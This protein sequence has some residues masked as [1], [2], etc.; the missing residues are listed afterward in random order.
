VGTSVATNKSE[1]KQK[2]SQ[3]DGKSVD[4]YEANKELYHEL[5][6]ALVGYAETDD[7]DPVRYSAETH[8]LHR[9]NVDADDVLYFLAS[10]TL[11][12]K[13]CG[14]VLETV[15][16]KLWNVKAK[17]YI[18]E[19]LQVSDAKLFQ[20]KG[21]FSLVRKIKKLIDQ[22]GR[23]KAS[24]ILNATGGFKATIPYMT[25]MGLIEGI[26]VTYIYE[27]QGVLIELPA[28]PLQFDRK[29]LEQLHQKS[30]DLFE[31]L[32]QG[33]SQRELARKLN[34]TREQL[35]NEY[36]DI[37]VFD[38]DKATLSILAQLYYERDYRIPSGKFRLY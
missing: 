10:D 1:L 36:K 15:S 13:L 6:D 18:L 20:Q 25:L 16:Q 4:E 9:M 21:V 33:I 7:F 31:Q 34:L 14:Q 11:Q 22:H 19:G 8:S 37:L 27:N 3:L 17:Y 28:V 26:P 24:F 12:G 38:G 32:K 29:A 35:R 2:F 30:G 23:D 5:F